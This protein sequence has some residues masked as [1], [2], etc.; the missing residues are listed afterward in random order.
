MILKINSFLLQFKNNLKRK[1]LIPSKNCK[2]FEYLR[3]AFLNYQQW[4]RDQFSSHFCLQSV[5]CA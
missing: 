5:W 2:I 4:T 1:N 3:V